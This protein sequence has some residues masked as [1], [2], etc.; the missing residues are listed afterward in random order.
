MDRERFKQD[1]ASTTEQVQA[2]FSRNKITK[3]KFK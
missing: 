2:K 1:L 3:I